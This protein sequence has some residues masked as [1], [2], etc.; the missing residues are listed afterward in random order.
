[1]KLSHFAPYDWIRDRFLLPHLVSLVNA[2][3]MQSG[4]PSWKMLKANKPSYNHLQSRPLLCYNKS[5]EQC[6]TLKGD[7]KRWL[8]HI[9][10]K[11][12]HPVFCEQ[13]E[14][15]DFHSS[16]PKLKKKK[17]WSLNRSC[18]FF[19]QMRRTSILMLSVHL[20][21]Y[22]TPLPP[23]LNFRPKW[24]TPFELQACA[25]T[26]KLNALC[27]LATN[28]KQREQISQAVDQLV[29]VN[30]GLPFIQCHR[31]SFSSFRC[32]PGEH[33]PV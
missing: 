3:C 17:N 9:L 15:W 33:F 1:M 6:L 16:I 31:L 2:Y 11:H 24:P 29:R 14:R 22:F 12:N 8:F 30:L 23:S 26:H 4:T 5:G 13:Y 20:N 21:R 7:N 10:R 18:V 28:L 19:L 32:T 25:R 27:I